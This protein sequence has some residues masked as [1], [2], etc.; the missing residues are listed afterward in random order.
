[1]YTWRKGSR[2]LF[3][4]TRK[5]EIP[6]RGLVASLERKPP[7]RV[8]GTAAFLT[9]DPESAPTALLHSLKHYKALHEKNVIL[10]IEYAPTPRVHASD[11]VL[12]EPISKTFSRVV[13]RFGF[14]E[15]P[16]CRA[17]S[18][19]PESAAGASTSC[20]RRSFCRARG[21]EI[22]AAFRPVDLAGPAVHLARR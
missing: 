9:S 7:V 20:P 15:S 8:P 13:L 17:R 22:L 12:I 14:M 21:A 16:T 19:S 6:L 3:Q 10:T 4:K 11:R 5:L 2:H 18:R 1:M